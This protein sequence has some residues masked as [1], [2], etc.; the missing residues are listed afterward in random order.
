MLVISAFGRLREE[1]HE[2]QA[3]LGYI[4]RCCL[5]TSTTITKENKPESSPPD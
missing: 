2:L 1:D 3:S 4:E 5:T